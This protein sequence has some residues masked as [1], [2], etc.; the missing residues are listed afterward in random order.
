MIAFGNPWGLLGLL[1]VPAILWLHLYRVRFPPLA[2]GGLFLWD[3][4]IRRPA[5]GRTR[6]RLRSTPSLWLEL[7]AA[8]LLGLLMGAP[9]LSWE[10]TA[11]HL[12]AVL[13]GSASM[14]ATTGG[15]TIG[16]PGDPAPTFRSDA[17][18]AL[19]DRAAGL[20]SN[21][22][23]TVIETGERPR[24]VGGPRRPYREVVAAFAA[25]PA[26]VRPRHGFAAGLDLA[27]RLAADGGEVVLLTDRDPASLAVSE[28]V[29]AISVGAPRPNAALLVA[30]RGPTADGTGEE[31]FLRVRAHGDTGPI[32]AVLTDATG[33][34]L[35][36]RTLAAP[37]GAAATATLPL[38]PGLRGRP[39][40]VALRAGVDALTADS[41]ALLL[42][43]PARPVRVAVTLPDGPARDAIE[44]ALDALPE[45]VRSEPNAADLRFAAT[46][47]DAEPDDG[48]WTVGV[49][50]LP[51]DGGPR[52]VRGPFL[53][54]RADPLT[55]GVS[56][57]GA[58]WGG[59]GAGTE[60]SHGGDAATLSPVIAA[61]D[62]VLL[63][64]VAGRADRFL[65]NVDPARGTLARTPDWPILLAN[66]VEARRSA[67]PGADRANLRVGE[68]ARLTLTREQAAD[69]RSLFLL[70]DGAAE[71]IELAR[72]PVVPVAPP[73]VGLWTVRDG[74]DGAELGRFSVRFADP[75]ESDLTRLSGG[76]IEPDGDAADGTTVD[77]P[78][79]W[80]VALLAAVALAAV[81]GDWWV[82]RPT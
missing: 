79:P 37:P 60:W 78:A 47:A 29:A 54:D 20:G 23:L 39:V 80:P 40:T 27:A 31:L 28:E 11:P 8:A 24:V 73:T 10:T 6:D 58:I 35:L 64:R 1:A 69:P 63:G 72:E 57:A 17:L 66:L 45:I 34:T 82:T 56:L 41:A 59:A 44:R 9:R 12:V 14:G 46:E 18:A 65:L 7:F 19:A 21:T 15:Q 49:G 33:A 52:D 71:P 32:A 13:D 68:S 5:G 42:P 16:T 22:L 77:D 76:L 67:L 36:E 38:P 4:A 50:P 55:A 25:R 26:P 81:V 2:I 75:R 70:G 48:V 62:R 3:D 51:G 43:E 74:P 61:G 53:I 30:Q